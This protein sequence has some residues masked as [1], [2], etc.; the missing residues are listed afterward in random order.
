MAMEPRNARL[1]LRFQ[2]KDKESHRRM[3]TKKK[4]PAIPI[5]KD[6]VCYQAISRCSRPNND[7]CGKFRVERDRTLALE[8]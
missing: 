2:S 3:Q 5:N 1:P 4:S 7:P 6:V 8:S